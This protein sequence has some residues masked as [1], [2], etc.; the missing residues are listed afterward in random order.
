MVFHIGEVAVLIFLAYSVGWVVG[1]VAR[2]LTMPRT[3]GVA[4]AAEQVGPTQGQAATQE[5]VAAAPIGVANVTAEAAGAA[6][7]EV[8]VAVVAEAPDVVTPTVL[9]PS[10]AEVIAATEAG[11]HV[12][13]EAPLLP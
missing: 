3:A 5:V 9:E 13:A 10:P 11:P 8:P 7:A 1:F 2:R 6:P 4:I 12:L